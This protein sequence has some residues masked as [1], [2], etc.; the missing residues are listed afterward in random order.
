LAKG[1]LETTL[2]ELARLHDDHDGR[3][4]VLNR[5]SFALL[6][7]PALGGLLIARLCA[8][9]ED[10]P[11]LELLAE[12]LG[13]VLDAARMAMENHKKRGEA[14]L[15]VVTDAVELAAG[16]WRLRSFHRL[17]L[18]RV[19]AQN[20]LKAPAALELTADDIDAANGD[21]ALE[22]RAEADAILDDLFRNLIEQS[23]GDALVLHAALIETFPAMPA[24]MR[25]H[26]I[27]GSVERSEPIHTRLA[28]FW[29]LDPAAPIRIA[30]ARA[31]A[32][33][34][35]TG[36]LSSDVTGKMVMLRSW[37]PDDDARAAVDQALKA[38]MRS[39]TATGTQVK[40]WTI[41]SVIATLPD[42]GGA[43]SIMIALQSG[44]SRKTA[45]LLLKQGYGIKDAYAI[46]CSSAREQ[47]ALIQRI[48]DETGV[49]KVPVPWL[50]STLSNALADGLAA[51]LPPVPGLIEV[52][53]LCGF[54]QLRPEAVT[55][56]ALI[57]ALPAAERIGGLSAQARGKLI[58]ASED[59]W[60]RHGIVQS[61][62]EESDHAH[63]VLEGKRSPRTLETALWK[64]LETRRDFWARLV[65]RGADVLAAAD[66]SDAPSFTAT[67]M[68]LLEGRDLKK[69]PVMADVHDQTI[70][71]WIFDD[72]DV[73]HDATL[74]EFVDQ[75]EEPE[76]ERKGELARLV[77]GSA[78]T[79]D[80][81]DGFLMS[82]TLAPKLIAPNRWLPEILSSAMATL[83]PGTIQRFADL[84]MMRAN[85]CVDQA[86]DPVQFAADMSRR[87]K[88][89]VRNWATGFSYACGQFKSSWPVK[90]AAPDDRAMMLRLSDAMST[91]FSVADVKTLSHWIA[92]RHARNV[93]A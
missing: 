81:I 41:H 40:P 6:H 80:W 28:C 53:E 13:S 47:K 77:K 30:A 45:M 25:A 15:T 63:E 23:D 68:A 74:E 37:M 51:D 44:G 84:I 62:F 19:W 88:M 93:G 9:E 3:R 83:E 12:M 60:D 43:Q 66:H 7:W 48:T 34:A 69:I 75:A 21:I 2:A 73:N 52:V 92:A 46:P 86:N 20:G 42:G 85:T 89:A 14:F 17:V 27:A 55:T 11:E 87:S 29:L 1:Q 65:A 38:A 79:V 57:A 90:S 33:R 35:S 4:E 78:V 64:W 39:G 91:G 8:T 71:A 16:Q 5:A 50:A 32:D 54:S 31:L 56:E 59:W 67:A 70:E 72:P 22:D 61:W 18:A 82:I 26:V 49:V 24:E 10:A 36:G 76:P 58:N